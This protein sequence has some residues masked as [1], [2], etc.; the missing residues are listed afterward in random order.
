MHSGGGEHR[1]CEN[2]ERGKA[3]KGGAGQDQ[4]E[5]DKA[6]EEFG[7]GIAAW[8]APD[9]TEFEPEFDS[10]PIVR[11]TVDEVVVGEWR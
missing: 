11:D 7:D 1:A 3:V 8:R 2:R 5:L 9:I 6:A 4:S 10:L